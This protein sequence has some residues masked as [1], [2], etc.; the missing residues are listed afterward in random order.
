MSCNEIQTSEE[1]QESS[2]PTIHHRSSLCYGTH[3]F[4]S[5]SPASTILSH[6]LDF[7]LQFFMPPLLSSFLVSKTNLLQ[8]SCWG[9]F[10]YMSKSNPCPFHLGYAY[11][12]VLLH[13]LLPTAKFVVIF[14]GN[15]TPRITRRHL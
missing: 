15:L 1:R 13:S 14:C 7:V 12:D 2:C 6:V 8:Q 10:Q 5:L 4:F 3:K 9:L 11:H